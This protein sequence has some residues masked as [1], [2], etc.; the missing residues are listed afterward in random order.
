MVILA[1]TCRHTVATKTARKTIETE[2][3]TGIGVIG[4]GIV[5]EIGE[6]I[7]TATVT[8]IVT[9]AGIGIEIVTETKT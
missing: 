6:I 4:T 8:G 7:A 5:I 9:E 3:V 1:T 2:I